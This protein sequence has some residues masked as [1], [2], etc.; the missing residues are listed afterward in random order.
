MSSV[1]DT[2]TKGVPYHLLEPG[3]EIRAE[4][5]AD[6]GVVLVTD[7]RLAV[8]F[9]TGR[10]ALDVPFEALR[11]IQF[12]IERTRPAT[13]VLVPEHP[14]DSPIVL[15]IRPE[16]YDAV[17]EALAVVGRMLQEVS[18]SES[19]RVSREEVAS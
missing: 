5:E 10:F 6:D 17:S 15:A 4:A 2:R 12:D 18:P 14:N 9:G 13:L 16:Q 11:R 19:D 7:R 1:P 8:S 3:E